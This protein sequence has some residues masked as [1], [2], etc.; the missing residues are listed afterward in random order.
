[1]NFTY[2]IEALSLKNSV[3]AEALVSTTLIF[4]SLLGLLVS[5]SFIIAA[6]FV[7]GCWDFAKHNACA[8]IRF[9]SWYVV[10]CFVVDTIYSLTLAIY[11]YK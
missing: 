8:G 7:H 5:P 6:I 2:L 9:F 10:P 4:A 11:F 3:T 1:M